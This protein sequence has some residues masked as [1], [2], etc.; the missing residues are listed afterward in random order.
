[1]KRL[2]VFAMVLS[3]AF[4]SCKVE[5]KN[6]TSDVNSAKEQKVEYASFG[7]EISDA[8]AISAEE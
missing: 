6:G 8:D 5:K 3:I 2:L 1:M 7:E 4:I